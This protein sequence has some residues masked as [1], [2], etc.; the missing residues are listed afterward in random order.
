[1]HNKVLKNQKVIYEYEQTII[2]LNTDINVE[3]AN[4]IQYD[5]TKNIDISNLEII[6]KKN[7]KTK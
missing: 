3:I 4:I 2:Q 5:N 6:K 7:K 1:M